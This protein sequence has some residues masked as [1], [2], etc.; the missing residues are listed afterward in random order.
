[1][2]N[3]QPSFYQSFVALTYDYGSR[4]CLK[5]YFYLH[6]L[7]LLSSAAANR[8]IYLCQFI[9]Q[10]SLQLKVQVKIS[11]FTLVYK[12]LSGMSKYFISSFHSHVCQKQ[13]FYWQL[14][15][16]IGTS[17]IISVGYIDDF[18]RGTCTG[19]PSRSYNLLFII[20]LCS[21]PHLTTFLQDFNRYI[22]FPK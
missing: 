19:A 11:S 2:I 8:Y 13:D 18:I 21:I 1:M 17:I 22:L 16:S 9:S 4:V 3:L 12:K 20:V 7:S 15:L 14:T 5:N 6:Y 10:G